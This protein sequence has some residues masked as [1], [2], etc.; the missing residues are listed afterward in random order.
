MTTPQGF[1]VLELVRTPEIGPEDRIEFKNG[2]NVVVGAPNTGKTKWLQMLDY[3]LGN[4]GPA[5]DVF[6]EDVAEKYETVTAR[7]LVAGEELEVRRGWK[8]AAQRARCF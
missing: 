5:E 4:D 6:G 2:V 8:E 1:M 3:I 7:L